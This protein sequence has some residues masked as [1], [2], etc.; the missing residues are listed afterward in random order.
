MAYRY[1]HLDRWQTALLPLG[2]L[3]DLVECHWQHE[4]PS[5]NGVEPTIDDIIPP[6]I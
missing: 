1:L 4:Q 6:G 2:V 3:L 5:R